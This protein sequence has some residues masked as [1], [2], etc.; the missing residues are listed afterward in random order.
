MEASKKNGEAFHLMKQ[1]QKLMKTA[2]V[3]ENLQLVTK[4]LVEKE[5]IKKSCRQSPVRYFRQIYENG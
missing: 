4:K 5:L 1:A 2:A 3:E